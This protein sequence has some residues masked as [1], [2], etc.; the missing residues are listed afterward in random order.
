M[1]SALFLLA[2]V[3]LWET[4]SAFFGIPQYLLP[5]PSDILI[6]LSE[7]WSIW[8][9]HVFITGLEAALGLMLATVIGVGFATAFLFS[10]TMESTTLPLLIAA[11]SMPVVAIAPLLVVW[12]GNG[13][14]PKVAIACIIAF[15][16]IVITTLRGLKSV[17]EEALDLFDSMGATK[18]DIFRL[19]R[20]PYAIPYFWAGAKVAATLAVIGAIVG[21]FVGADK[22]LGFMIVISSH[23][24]ETAD[25]FVGALL[26]TL[27]S[28]LAYASATTLEGW[29]NRRFGAEPISEIET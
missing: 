18:S 24:L 12:L 1:K 6:R 27:L 28:L 26:A 19:L 22:G 29:T 15:F 3:A 14:A 10:K 11:K 4:A 8:L 20:L 23:R 2:L 17:S 21:E 13:I 5:A 16:P 7:N 9:S 25:M